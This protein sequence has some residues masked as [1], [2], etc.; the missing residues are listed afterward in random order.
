[1][2]FRNSVYNM[3]TAYIKI[4]GPKIASDELVS[5]QSAWRFCIIVILSLCVI[6]SSSDIYFGGSPLI[7]TTESWRNEFVPAKFNF[8]GVYAVTLNGF[9]NICHKHVYI[10]VADLLW[11][12]S[13]ALYVRQLNRIALMGSFHLKQYREN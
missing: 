4:F 6:I 3:P 5:S 11:W 9:A 1:M 10:M 8:D 2:H 7:Y 12:N 13:K